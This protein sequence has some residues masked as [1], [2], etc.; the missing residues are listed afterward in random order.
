MD[1]SGLWKGYLCL[2]LLAIVIATILLLMG[3]SL[4]A[5][6]SIL[7]VFFIPVIYLANLWSIK[8]RDSEEKRS[9]S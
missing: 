1:D 7:A 9:S 3:T 8:Q 6:S 5:Q 4:V 2:E